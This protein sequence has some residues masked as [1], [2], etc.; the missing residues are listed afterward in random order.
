[1]HNRRAVV[2]IAISALVTAAAA[3]MAPPLMAD[4]ESTLA[5][6]LHTARSASQCPP[7]QSDPFVQRVAEMALQN[8]S[9]Y[10]SHRTAAVPFTDPMPA[11]KVIGYTGSKAVLLSGYGA[12]DAD[13]V[14]GLILQGYALIP[15]CSYT[16]YGTSAIRDA[17][18]F[19]LTSVVLAR[20]D[21]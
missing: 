4:P 3:V 20:Q 15:D 12:S 2:L 21:A 9:D 6:A 5:Q 16:Q 1:M 18:G 19:N 13:A 14:H 8:T 11:L 17:G 10:I 7:L